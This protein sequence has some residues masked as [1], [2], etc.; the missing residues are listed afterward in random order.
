MLKVGNAAFRPDP[1]EGLIGWNCDMLLAGF[2]NQLVHP[3]KNSLG[4]FRSE[5]AKIIEQISGTE[6][7]SHQVRIVKCPASLVLYDTDV[8][9]FEEQRVACRL[10][11]LDISLRI[12][13][14]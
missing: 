8:Q 6:A 4:P 7:F 13:D 11:S 2:I 10:E 12:L 3:G 5:Q 1:Y 9:F 14:Q